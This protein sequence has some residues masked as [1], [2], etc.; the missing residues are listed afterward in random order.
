MTEGQKEK[1][2]WEGQSETGRV[3]RECQLVTCKRRDIVDEKTKE[4]REKKK[5]GTYQTC[6]RERRQ[7]E[8]TKQ[9]LALKRKDG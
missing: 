1:K 6:K 7:R 9:W 5:Q 8:Q 3:R 2:V 4:V